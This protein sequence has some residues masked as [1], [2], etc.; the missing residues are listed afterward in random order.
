MI[1]LR[2]IMYLIHTDFLKKSIRKHSV[3]I[4]NP[5]NKIFHQTL[6]KQQV[7]DTSNTMAK[8]YSIIPINVNIV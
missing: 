7:S 6:N 1:M 3:E 4:L 2:M 5:G 8:K